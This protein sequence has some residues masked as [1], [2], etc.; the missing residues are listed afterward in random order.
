MAVIQSLNYCQWSM[1]YEADEKDDLTGVMSK[2]MTR[3]NRL[4]NAKN[5]IKNYLDDKNEIVKTISKGMTLGI[6]LLID[7][8]N[9]MIEK[10]RGMSNLDEKALRDVEYDFARIGAQNKEGWQAIGL[11]AAWV[12][13]V[14][15]EFGK[16]ENPKGKIPFKISDKE[17]QYLRTEIE[18]LFKDRLK[19]FENYRSLQKAG[20]EG[21]P[22]DQTWLIVTVDR[23]KQTLSVETY[24]EAKGKGL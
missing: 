21:D 20:K 16:T 9:K 18:K 12:M 23:I 4:E 14:F 19:R 22:N 3:N 6:D 15:A 8:N 1:D 10:I 13:A 2:T 17:R 24:E 5:S 7:S 11:S